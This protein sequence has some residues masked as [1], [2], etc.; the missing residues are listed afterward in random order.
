MINRPF[1]EAINHDD[2]HR[3]AQQHSDGSMSVKKI[4]KYD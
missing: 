2:A 3:D 4:T 1:K